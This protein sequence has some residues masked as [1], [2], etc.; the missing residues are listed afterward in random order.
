MKTAKSLDLERFMGDWFVIANIP[1]YFEAKAF[2][3]VESYRLGSNGKIE[4]TFAFNAGASDGP[5][6]EIKAT[7]V[8]KDPINPA[9][10]GMRFF[11]PLSADY[12]VMF[13]DT[14]YQHTVVGRAK[15]DFLWIMARNQ[16]VDLNTLNMLIDV[17]VAE[18]YERNK[19]LL[20]SWQKQE[21]RKAG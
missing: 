13:V 9:I 8:V 20:T 1:T 17:A 21:L 7:G 5:A 16:P 3:P 18:G 11:W 12:R 6:K 2:N 15:R 14:D 19:I 10:W 4:T